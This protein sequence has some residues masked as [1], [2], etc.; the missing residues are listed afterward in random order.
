MRWC[1]WRAARRS[2]R[3]WPTRSR[4]AA[5]RGRMSSCSTS[6]SPTPPARIEDELREH[7]LEPQFVVNNAGFGLLGPAASLDRAAAARDDRPQRA[8]ADR[9]VAALRRQPRA[10]PAAAS[11]T[12]PRSRASCRGPAWPS[13]TPP[14]PMCCRSARRCTASLAPQGVRVTALCPGPV[15]TDGCVGAG[16][17]CGHAQVER[18]ARAG[19]E[20]SMQE[21]VWCPVAQQVSHAAAPAARAASMLYAL[22]QLDVAAIVY[23]P[24]GPF[25]P[26]RPA[27]SLQRC[28]SKAESIESWC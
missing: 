17:A 21:R 16:F 6:A 15:D 18:V 9:P 28:G 3:R 20:G 25:F 24:G 19:F 7:G 22:R 26:G 27:A 5:M 12:S 8:R 4:S 1:W 10:A 13:I 23:R 2:S 14:R 11:S